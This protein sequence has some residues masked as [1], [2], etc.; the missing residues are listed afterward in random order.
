VIEIGVRPTD[1]DEMDMLL[2]HEICHAVSTGG[3]GKVWLARLEKAAQKAEKVGRSRLAELL[4][5]EITRYQNPTVGSGDAY[6]SIVDWVWENPGLTLEQVKKWLARDYGLL[7]S[8][9]CRVLPRT[10]KV[11]R[12][13]KNEASKA[14]AM[15]LRSSE[16]HLG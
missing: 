11:F 6:R 12:K 1:A 9:V 15:R 3:H 16:A 10:E 5:E 2:I 8:E 4:R 13:A 14:E 7:V